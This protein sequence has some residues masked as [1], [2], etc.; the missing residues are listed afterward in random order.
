[1]FQKKKDYQEEVENFGSQMSMVR[2]KQ[3]VYAQMLSEVTAAIDADGKEEGE[4]Q[5]HEHSLTREYSKK[6]KQCKQK[7]EEILFTNICA[8]REVRDAVLENSIVS[9]PS[10][11]ADCDVED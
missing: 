5:Q 4:K 8:V 10:A 9:P 3:T 1:M 7:I 6:M 11:I 2:E